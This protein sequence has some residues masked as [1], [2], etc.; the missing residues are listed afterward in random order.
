MK[1]KISTLQEIKKNKQLVRDL[2]DLHGKATHTMKMW[3][4]GNNAMLC[5]ID[6]LNL[7]SKTLGIA[8]ED[9]IEDSNN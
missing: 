1:L 3:L 7:I 6:S 2:E 8:I 4:L 9:L 5:H